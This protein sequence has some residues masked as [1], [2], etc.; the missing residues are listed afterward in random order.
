MTTITITVGGVTITI[1]STEAVSVAQ[2]PAPEKPEVRDEVLVDN[3][4]MNRE[5]DFWRPLIGQRVEVLTR[6]GDLWTV[7]VPGSPVPA[8][9]V[10]CMRFIP[11]H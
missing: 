10:D 4:D 3:S 7:A 6:Q 2:P 5:N 1:N 8:I 9:D 11:P